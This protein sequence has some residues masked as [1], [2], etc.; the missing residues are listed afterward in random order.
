VALAN[1]IENPRAIPPGTLIDLSA[2]TP[3]IVSG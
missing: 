3:R 2:T 1:G